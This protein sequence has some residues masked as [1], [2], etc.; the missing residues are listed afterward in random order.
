LLTHDGIK[1]EEGLV[2]GRV[3]QKEIDEAISR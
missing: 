1:L 2:G 3:K